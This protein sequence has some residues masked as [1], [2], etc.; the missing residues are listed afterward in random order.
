VSLLLTAAI[1]GWTT[2]VL[3][4]GLVLHRSRQCVRL[5][6]QA[7]TD[8]TGLLT[9]AA[10][11]R[12][13]EAE[14]AR[15][16]RTLTPLALAM[17]DID[18]FKQINDRFGHLAGDQVLRMAAETILSQLRPYDLAGRFGGDEVVLLLPET[19]ARQ[20]ECVVDR[21]R[22]AVASAAAVIGAGSVTVSAGISE[23]G[24][25]ATGLD[26]LLA[27]ADAALYEA[28]RAGRNQI[29]CTRSPQLQ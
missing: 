23:L 29:R 12:A 6:E 10:W 13:A 5:L 28:K 19:T 14:L 25:G 2:V 21:V 15:A 16:S 4:A 18:H 9:R 26:G 7:R 27:A 22:G 24:G 3:A 8:W 20:A 1:A 17:L 11:R